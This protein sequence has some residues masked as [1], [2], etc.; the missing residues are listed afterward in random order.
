MHGKAY[1]FRVQPGSVEAGQFQRPF[2]KR[3][4]SPSITVIS[5]LFFV[6]FGHLFAVCE[7]LNRH[8]VCR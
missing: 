4:L 2:Q 6:Q 7:V 3:V 1:F 5:I 8:Q